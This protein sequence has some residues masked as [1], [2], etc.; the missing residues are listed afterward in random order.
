MLRKIETG[1]YRVEWLESIQRSQIRTVKWIFCPGHTGV[2]E[3]E[4]ADKLAGSVQV[5][6]KQK[7][8]YDKD[9]G[10]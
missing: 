9:D 2:L 4:W 6:G 7:L 1:M 8:G 3:N 5:E 10:Y